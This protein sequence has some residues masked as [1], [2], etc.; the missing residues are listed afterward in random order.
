MSEPFGPVLPRVMVRV[1]VVATMSALVGCGAPRAASSGTTTDVASAT[2]TPDADATGVS[3]AATEEEAVGSG[4][5]GAAG[6]ALSPGPAPAEP[7]DL[8]LPRKED[9][10]STSGITIRYELLSHKHAVGGGSHG[11]YQVTFSRGDETGTARFGASNDLDFWGEG[12]AFGFLFQRLG[13]ESGKLKLRLYAI[14]APP[15]I[16]EARVVEI[17]GGLRPEKTDSASRGSAT[18]GAYH[19]SFRDSKRCI[20]LEAI[21]GAHTGEVLYMGTPEEPCP[22]KGKG[23]GKKKKT[24]LD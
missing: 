6:L 18:G 23:K 7:E 9:V 22:K 16:D 14:D 1:F 4:G 8:L 3:L 11:E 24:V 20:L 17:M 2:S 10:V 12:S 21:V 13:E 19:L 15:L 5:G